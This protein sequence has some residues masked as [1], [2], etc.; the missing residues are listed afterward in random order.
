[1]DRHRRNKH[2]KNNSTSKQLDEFPEDFDDV[3]FHNHTVEQDKKISILR[4]IVYK[5]V[6]NA[7]IDRV[8]EYKGSD[9]ALEDKLVVDFDTT[10]FSDFQWA[11]IREE[12]QEHG[13]DARFGLTE[14]KISSFHIPVERSINLTETLNEKETRERKEKHGDDSSSDEEDI[15]DLEKLNPSGRVNLFK[16]DGTNIYNM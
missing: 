2:Q 16:A 11:V 6:E 8:S 15:P 14:G 9:F 5:K 3:F 12:L 7:V 13:F 4:N 10:G 1:M